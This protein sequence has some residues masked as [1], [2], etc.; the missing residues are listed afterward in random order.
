MKSV[1]TLRVHAAHYGNS[2]LPNGGGHD[3]DEWDIEAPDRPTLAEAALPVGADYHHGY[4]DLTGNQHW[5][6]YRKAPFSKERC[7]R[8]PEQKETR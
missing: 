5:I 2:T 8:C 1:Y 3:I 4:R 6:F 7:E